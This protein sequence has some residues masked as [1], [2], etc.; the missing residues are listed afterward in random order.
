MR[1][2]QDELAAQIKAL[3][4]PKDPNDAKD[5]NDLP[6]KTAKPVVVVKDERGEAAADFKKS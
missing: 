3:L 4:V 2:R 6:V 1:Q 5:V